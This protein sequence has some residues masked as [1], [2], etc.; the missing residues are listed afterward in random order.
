MPKLGRRE[1]I[2][3]PR[4]MFANDTTRIASV[5]RTCAVCG[6]TRSS[7]ALTA[8]A[9]GTPEAFSRRSAPQ[10]KGASSY[11]LR[12][13]MDERQQDDRRSGSEARQTFGILNRPNNGLSTR[14]NSRLEIPVSHRKQSSRAT[15]TRYKTHYSLVAITSLRDALLRS[16]SELQS[17]PPFSVFPFH[18]SNSKMRPIAHAMKGSK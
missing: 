3:A 11:V 4:K 8:E 16:S 2:R 7:S 14:Y 1:K 10:R 17:P 5:A 6:L 15:S 13:A 9:G 18:F 12:H